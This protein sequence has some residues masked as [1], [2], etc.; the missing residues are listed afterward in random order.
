MKLTLFLIEHL[1]SNLSYI[2][3]HTTTRAKQEKKTMEIQTKLS[4]E[5]MEKLMQF[6]HDKFKNEKLFTIDEWIKV[7]NLDERK[8]KEIHSA[9]EAKC[10]IEKKDCTWDQFCENVGIMYRY[11]LKYHTAYVFTQTLI[12]DQEIQKSMKMN[13]SIYEEMYSTSEKQR[14]RLEKK[15]AKKKNKGKKFKEQKPDI[16]LSESKSKEMVEK[17]HMINETITS[18]IS[19]NIEMFFPSYPDKFKKIWTKLL[20]RLLCKDLRLGPEIFRQY[21]IIRYELNYSLWDWVEFIVKHAPYEIMLNWMNSVDEY[22][23]GLKPL[24]IELSPDVNSVTEKMKNLQ[25]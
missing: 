22:Y 25:Q 15:A 6:L 5:E 3:T 21:P 2:T 9:Y 23:R 24:N 16:I 12:D 7:E 19:G 14:E 10:K 17:M 8:L 4:T 20:T 13:D 11:Q 1:W 18:R